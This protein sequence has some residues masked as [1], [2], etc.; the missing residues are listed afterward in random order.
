MQPIIPK[1]L[2]SSELPQ[3]LG[4]EVN[5]SESNR[6]VTSS[7]P[8]TFNISTMFLF[9]ILISVLVAIGAAIPSLGI[10]FAG[11]SVP[12]LV[13]TAL[14]LHKRRQL[15]PNEQ[16]SMEVKAL[17]FI[18]S[19][20]ASLFVIGMTIFCSL[21]CACAAGWIVVSIFGF[22]ELAALFAVMIAMLAGSGVA[23]FLIYS[24]SKWSRYCWERDTRLPTLF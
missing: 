8:M 16:H 19:L 4:N 12:P 2:V 10:L 23:V 22:V 11:L 17:L 3:R 18:R 14:V 15:Y 9:T 5:I 6:R 20:L 21:G 1:S 7:S 13:R 24:F